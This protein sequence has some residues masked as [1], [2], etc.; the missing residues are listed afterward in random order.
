VKLA[1]A[2]DRESIRDTL[3]FEQ[4]LY[5]KTLKLARA[6]YLL[7][8]TL[9]NEAISLPIVSCEYRIKIRHPRYF[10]FRRRE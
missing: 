4:N 1:T 9:V 8:S 7:Y 6:T 3:A 10:F 5:L 2:I